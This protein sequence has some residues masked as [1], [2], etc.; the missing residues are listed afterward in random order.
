MNYFAIYLN[1]TFI[2]FITEESQKVFL[3]DC[4]SDYEFYQ[5][6][7]DLDSPPMPSNVSLIN[8]EL[9]VII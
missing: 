1:E 3:L 5:F 4:N 6:T 9:Q 2:G 8:D 7:W